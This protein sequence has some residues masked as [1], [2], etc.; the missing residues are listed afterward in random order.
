[1]SSPPGTPDP[2][3]PE[4]MLAHIRERS[5]IG[6]KVRNLQETEK[7]YRESLSEITAKNQEFETQAKQY[8][9]QDPPNMTQAKAKVKLI[10]ANKAREENLKGYMVRVQ[11]MLPG[12]IS[13]N[14]DLEFLGT[15]A[16]PVE[17]L[18]MDGRKNAEFKRAYELGKSGEAIEKKNKQVWKDYAE[19]QE[20]EDQELDDE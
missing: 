2:Y 5:T 17:I 13:L 9:G 4:A 6:P 20:M 7:N 3:S 16:L 11:G 10:K 18:G 1:M 19:E 15:L 8:L 12:L 14:D